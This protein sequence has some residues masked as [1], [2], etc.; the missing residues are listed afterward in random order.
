MARRPLISPEAGRAAL[1]AWREGG[2]STP[3]TDLATA[4]RFTLQVFA[5]E[6]PGEAVELR[7]PPFHAVQCIEGTRHT[8]GTPPAVVEMDAHTWLALACGIK[9]WSDATRPGGG[10]TASGERSDLSALLPVPVAK[11]IV[12]E[13]TDVE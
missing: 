13:R 10:A 2:D 9:E 12:N 11:R 5:A 4:V 1:R 3:R 7:V 8:R 6:H